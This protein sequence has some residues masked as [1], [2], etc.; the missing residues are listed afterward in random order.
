MKQWEQLQD[1][2]KFHPKFP[3]SFALNQDNL[4]QERDLFQIL[5]KVNKQMIG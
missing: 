3:P 2:S 5:T 1:P 4:I